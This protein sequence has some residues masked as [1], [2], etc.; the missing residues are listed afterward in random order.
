M[1]R[2]NRDTQPFFFLLKTIYYIYNSKE[3][4]TTKNQSKFS[5]KVVQ[6]R[7]I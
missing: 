4:I 6:N 3:V 7:D 1:E 5:H 2:I